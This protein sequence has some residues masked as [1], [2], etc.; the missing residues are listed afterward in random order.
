MTVGGKQSGS[1]GFFVEPTVF[2]G[3]EDHFKIAQEV[4]KLKILAEREGSLQRQPLIDREVEEGGPA[5]SG[6]SRLPRK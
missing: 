6:P 2:S 5:G 4:S 1:E 3:V